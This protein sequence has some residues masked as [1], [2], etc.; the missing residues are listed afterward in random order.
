M[1]ADKLFIVQCLHWAGNEFHLLIELNVPKLYQFCHAALILELIEFEGCS[2]S[3]AWNRG[4]SLAGM[5]RHKY[6]QCFECIAQLH[7]F[8]LPVTQL[9]ESPCTTECH[10]QFYCDNN[11]CKPRCDR[12]EE[13]SH[14][15]VITSD[16]VVAMC[17]CI[18]VLSGLSVL[19]ISFLRY[20]KM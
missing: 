12:F 20:K 9:E 13:F 4:M 16:V 19:V 2:F 14:S 18:C 3:T 1:S 11:F 5:M 10:E 17:A 6:K 7:I 8:W 15:Y